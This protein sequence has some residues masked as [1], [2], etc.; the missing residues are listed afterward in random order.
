VSELS[1][2]QSPA[3]P[4]STPNRQV[5]FTQNRRLTRMGGSSGNPVL[6]ICTK[7]ARLAALKSALVLTSAQALNWAAFE[8]AARQYHKLQMDRRMAARNVLPSDDPVERLHQ[9][10]RAM[11]DAAAALQELA[12]ATEPLYRSLEENQKLRLAMLGPLPR[13]HSN[14]SRGT[15]A[16]SARTRTEGDPAQTERPYLER[17]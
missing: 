9:R 10:A 4:S 17:H 2:L 5:L 8:Q 11:S 14:Q 15:S 16:Q 6:K 7:Q 12:E 13:L 1:R 3:H